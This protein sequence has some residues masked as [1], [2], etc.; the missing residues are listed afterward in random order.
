VT[1][2]IVNQGARRMLSPSQ[3]LGKADVGTSNSKHHL[4]SGMT[5]RRSV[6]SLLT[7]DEARRIVANTAN[8]LRK[9]LGIGALAVFLPRVLGRSGCCEQTLT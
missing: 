6:A 7:S 2:R 4:V 5:G 1:D 3:C 8:S 9:N